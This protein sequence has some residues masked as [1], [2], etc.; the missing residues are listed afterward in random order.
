MRAP[1]NDS[2]PVA[3][4][5]PCCVVARWVFLR[6]LGCVFLAAFLSAW[7]QIHG[8]IGS[9][10]ILPVATHLAQAEATFGDEAYLRLPTLCWLDPSDEFL[11]A[12]CAG[13]AALSGLL[14]V[15]VAPALVLL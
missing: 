5:D 7:S 13:G 8:L 2:V 6:M 3:P 9:G 1:S 14:I 4:P 15:G 11:N 12:L 10:G